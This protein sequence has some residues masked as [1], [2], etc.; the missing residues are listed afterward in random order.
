MASSSYGFL[1]RLAATLTVAV[2]AA[3]VVPGPPA[4][5]EAFFLT[6]SDLPLMP[7]LEES[8]ESALVFDNP[9]GRLVRISAAGTRT[10]QSILAFYGDTLPQLGWAAMAEDQ[11]EREGEVLRLVFGAGAGPT[12]VTFSIS[13]LAAPAP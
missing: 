1:G 9:G 3:A 13:P 8:P 7:G 11:F 10:R 12:V 6:I 2:A 4:A 5:Q